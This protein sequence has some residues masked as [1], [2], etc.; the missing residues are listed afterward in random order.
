MTN[1]I[2]IGG[3]PTTGK[4][5]LARKLGDQLKMPWISTD[6][7]RDLMRKTVRKEDYVELFHFDDYGGQTAEKYLTSKTAIEIVDD[8]N[9][10][11][12][13]VWKGS[14]ALIETDYV[15]KNF[16]IEGVAILPIFVNKILK[17][18]VNILPIFLVDNNVERIRNTVFTR[19]LWDD[20]KSYP[21][22]VKEK[23]VEWVLEFNKYISE[24]C[25]KFGYIVIEIGDRDKTYE[26][27][28]SLVVEW[29]K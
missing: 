12:E 15:W 11:S 14:L 19:G 6:T 13:E 3:A 5:Y 26:K 21:D 23:E 7:I 24:E 4:S 9:K 25:K 20:A 16:I 18:D 28:H 22:S 1:T 10:E 17:K 2:L 29:L 8:Q 27:I